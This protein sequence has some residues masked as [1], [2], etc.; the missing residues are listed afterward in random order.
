MF[1]SIAVDSELNGPG[2]DAV[3]T[4]IGPTST[5]VESSGWGIEMRRRHDRSPSPYAWR[6]P[7]Q[8]LG[9]AA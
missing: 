8:D 5:S 3:N 2:L 7:P 9:P 6:P 4:Y 1:V